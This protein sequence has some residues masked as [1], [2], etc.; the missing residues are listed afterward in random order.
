[1]ASRGLLRER[2]VRTDRLVSV[3]WSDGVAQ[4]L[5]PR[6]LDGGSVEVD[7]RRARRGQD[8]LQGLRPDLTLSRD[9]SRRGAPTG[10]APALE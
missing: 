4:R 5:I 1:M 2:T 3:R 6:D 7:P 10:T 9:R 8:R